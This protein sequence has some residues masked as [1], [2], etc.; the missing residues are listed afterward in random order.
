MPKKG[1]TGTTYKK[2]LPYE[3]AREYVH[4]LHL[5]SN[6]EYQ[7][8]SKSGERPNYIPS[9][10]PIRYKD[11]GWKNWG[12]W[13]GHCKIANQY[14]EFLPYEEARAFVHKLNLKGVMGWKKYCLSGDRPDN[15]PSCP[16]ETYK[17]KG[18]KNYSDWTNYNLNQEGQK[19]TKGGR[20]TCNIPYDEAKTF[21]HKLNIV[22]KLQWK[23]YCNSGKKH[24]RIPAKPQ[25]V[26]KDK[27]W[28]NWNDWLAPIPNNNIQRRRNTKETTNKK[29][30]TPYLPFNEARTFVRNLKFK[31]KEEW[32]EY[33]KENK[34]PLNI[35]TQPQKVYNK[36]GW[37]NLNDWLDNRKHTRLDIATKITQENNIYTWE[38]Y[39]EFVNKNPQLRLP[40]NPTRTYRNHKDW[41][42]SKHF[43]CHEEK[44]TRF[45]TLPELKKIIRENKKG[46]NIINKSKYKEFA[47]NNKHLRIPVNPE[48]V[49]KSHN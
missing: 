16:N 4:G 36:K 1:T 42:G 31:S 25:K 18:W 35:P 2:F 3:E 20:P 8:W 9:C 33:V 40:I 32:E 45:V 48:A 14:R 29:F 22:T 39:R 34:L 6:K 37:I 10:P 5:E 23:E 21:V 7:E 47:R 24:D 17:K 11:K 44:L 28:T 49:Y 27:G 38:E 13:L 43:L 30:R 26:Y 12:D 46:W 15:I 41:K 19:L